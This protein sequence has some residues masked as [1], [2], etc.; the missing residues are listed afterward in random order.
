MN[1]STF[2][3]SKVIPELSQEISEE[4]PQNILQLVF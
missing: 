2:N 3:L 4:V 1:V